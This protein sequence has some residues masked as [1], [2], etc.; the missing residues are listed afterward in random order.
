MA[1]FGTV[2]GDPPR[3]SCRACRQPIADGEPFIHLRF[4]STHEMTGLYHRRC[5]RPFES[6]A[7]VLNMNP[8][9]H[10]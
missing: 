4:G 8:W 7:R 5:G 9:G 3:P 10:F 6:F 1:Y 2:G